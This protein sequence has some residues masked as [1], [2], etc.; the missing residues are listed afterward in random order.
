MQEYADLENEPLDEERIL[1]EFMCENP[2]AGELALMREALESRR[3]MFERERQNATDERTLQTL[4][5][6][7]KELNQQIAALEREERIT[8]FVEASVRV[9]LH[10]PSEEWDE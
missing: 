9:T 3:E 6:K 5:A 1:D 7:L 4:A 2:R 8:Q 10:K